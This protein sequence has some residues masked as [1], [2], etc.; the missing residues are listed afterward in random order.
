MSQALAGPLERFVGAVTPALTGLAADAGAPSGDLGRDVLTEAADLVA[1]VIDADGMHT[2]EELRAYLTTFAPH[3][4]GSLL[5]A[6]PGDLRRSGLFAGRRAFLERATSMFQLLADADAQDGGQ[7]SWVYYRVALD[8]AHAVAALDIHTSQIELDALARF[9]NMLLTRIKTAG[10]ARPGPEFFGID[11]AQLGVVRQR[12]HGPGG[13]PP[14]PQPV[15]AKEAGPDTASAPK[16]PDEPARPVEELL[17]E[18]DELVGLEPVKTEVRLITN[19]LTIQKLREERG[20]P[21]TGGSRH[22]VFAGNPGT[23][24]TTV[25]RLLSEIYRSLG[26]VKVGHLVETDRSGMVA[27]FVGQTATKTRDIVLSALG[28]VLLIDEAYALARGSDEDFGREAIDTLVKMMEDHRDDLVIIAAGYPMEMANLIRANP[29][30]RSRFPKTLHFDD[31]DNDE[32]AS[33]FTIIATKKH[34]ELGEGVEE[35]VTKRFMD[36]PRGRGFGNGRLARNLFEA[37]IA[38]Q[39]TRLVEIDNP[40]DE[41]LITLIAADIPAVPETNPIDP[42]TG[43]LLS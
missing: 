18:L 11:P 3:D 2:D 13:V 16:A 17:A 25:A 7:R 39:A 8:L 22:L 35:I 1:G 33:I 10:V 5:H 14:Q 40:T 15:A 42:A 19:L 27:G 23:G 38:E 26:I 43:E 21:T 28:G 20:L 9:R 4:D 32:L 30:L 12:V 36:V 29:G 41:Q 6:T 24:K 37:A 31:Y 34:Y